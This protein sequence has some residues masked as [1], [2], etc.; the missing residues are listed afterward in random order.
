VLPDRS[1]SGRGIGEN[2]I[3]VWSEKRIETLTAPVNC[4][5][6]RSHGIDHHVAVRFDFQPKILVQ[7]FVV[8]EIVGQADGASG[9]S[10]RTTRENLASLLVALIALHDI[11]KFASGFQFK[12]PEHWPADVLG[13]MPRSDE[14]LD[15]E[16]TGASIACASA[17]SVTARAA[18][19]D[20]SGLDLHATA[21]GPGS[22]RWP[23]PDCADAGDDSCHSSELLGPTRQPG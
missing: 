19:P 11:G 6:D 1:L 18:A 10:A 13:P 14:Q 21:P 16:K 4:I 9:E 7:L 12:A 22:R 8:L 17:C 3:K 23:L 2:T 5:V 20:R 15:G